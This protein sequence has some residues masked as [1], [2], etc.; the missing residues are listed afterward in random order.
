MMEEAVLASR[1]FINEGEFLPEVTS[2][3][4]V[5]EGLD[6]SRRRCS[7]TSPRPPEAARR[8]PAAH[9]TRPRPV[10]GQLAGRPGRATVVDLGRV[11][12]LVA[13]VGRAGTATPTFWGD[14]V[15][16]TF[17]A[18]DA[19]S[20]WVRG[21][22]RRTACCELTVESADA[23]A[24]GSTIVVRVTDPELRPVDVVL[25]RTGPGEFS[26]EVPVDVA[27]TYAVGAQV[28]AADGTPTDS[29]H[30]PGHALLRRPSSSPASPTRPPSPAWPRPPADGAPSRRPRRSTRPTSGPA[31]PAPTWRRGW[32][33]PPACS[34]RSPSP[35]AGSTCGAAPSP[36]PAPSP[37]GGSG[38]SSP[39]APAARTTRRPS[40]RPPGPPKPE[41]APKE[42]KPEV[43]MPS[44]LGTLLDRK[45]GAPPV[46]EPPPDP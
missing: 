8:D 5:V 45:R 19:G 29:R 21:A 3:A 2:G 23:F 1:D 40:P 36:T 31:G 43:A 24:D 17:P 46:A 9:R 41:R 15:R 7:A 11:G 35:S 33:W 16:D 22:G 38:R 6:R 37:G 4:E 42:A 28:L 30:R 32:C 44:T 10:A 27:G 13:A 14:V 25:T 39:P 26:G 18:G 20:D 12:P 34:S